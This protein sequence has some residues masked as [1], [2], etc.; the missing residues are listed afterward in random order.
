M[1]L[2]EHAERIQ[3]LFLEGRRDEAVLEVPVE[4]ADEISLVGS[5]ARIAERVAAWKESAVTEILVAAGSVEQLRQAAEL[6]LPA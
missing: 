4:F 1:G 5:P 2:G 6:I 3:D